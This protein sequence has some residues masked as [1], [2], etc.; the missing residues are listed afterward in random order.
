MTDKTTCDETCI[1]CNPGAAHLGEGMTINPREW[2]ALD[3]HGTQIWVYG[4]RS[5]DIVVQVAE[6]G[7]QI[8]QFRDENDRLRRENRRL[9]DQIDR[10]CREIAEVKP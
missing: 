9:R 2:T 7:D 5:V 8:R 6:L 4:D 1:D 3:E 10:L